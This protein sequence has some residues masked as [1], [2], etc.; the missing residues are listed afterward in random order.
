MGRGLIL[1]THPCK[2]TLVS[3]FL[4]HTRSLVRSLSG[5]AETNHSR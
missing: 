3:T 4:E 5:I 2:T 1:A